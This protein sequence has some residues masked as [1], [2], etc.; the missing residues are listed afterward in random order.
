MATIAQDGYISYTLKG[1]TC[2]I[3]PDYDE[4]ENGKET[5]MYSIQI[6]DYSDNE[7]HAYES[8]KEAKEMLKYLLRYGRNP[9]G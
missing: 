3:F 4:D 5:A 7:G 6:G 8:I 1:H 2:C 9:L